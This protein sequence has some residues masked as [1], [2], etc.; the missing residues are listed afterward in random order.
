MEQ[1]SRR[2]FLALAG[3]GVALALA[4]CR[5]KPQPPVSTTTTPPPTALAYR[6]DPNYGSDAVA[7]P[8]GSCVACFAC[9]AHAANRI[10]PS[11]EPA[12]A[13]PGCKCLVVPDPSITLEA[14]ATLFQNPGN[15]PTGGAVDRRW[16][17]VAQVLSG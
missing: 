7:C 4:A 6:M 12:R 9:Q 11:A 14:Y 15:N 2:R 5:P 10:L 1:I 3:G 16:Q 13:H 8:D 17:W